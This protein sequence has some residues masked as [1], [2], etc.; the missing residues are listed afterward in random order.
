MSLFDNK[1]IK[2]KIE[3]ICFL[4]IFSIFTDNTFAQNG[5]IE[6]IPKEMQNEFVPVLH[7]KLFVHTDKT[8]YLPGELIWFKIYAIDGLLN[9]PSTFSKV[10]YV[11]II[12]ADNKAVLQTKISLESAIGKG[13]LLVP[14][15]ITS[16]NYTLRAYTQ[17]MR[18]FGADHFFEQS[19]SIVNTLK[20]S[21]IDAAKKVKTYHVQFFPEGGDLI[22]G[23]SSKLAFKITDQDNSAVA[24]KGSIINQKKDTVAHFHTLRFGMGSLL[25][26]PEKDETYTAIIEL[27]DTSITAAIPDALKKGFAMQVVDADS[28][29][30]KIAVTTNSSNDKSSI[31]F[32]AQSNHLVKNVQTNNLSNGIAV[33][34]VDKK[35]I[36]DGI[37][38]FTIFDAG[39]QPVCER[40]YFKRPT[41][42]L[43]IEL[44]SDQKK[45]SIRNKVNVTVSTTDQSAKFANADLSMS[46][47]QTNSFQTDVYQDIYNYLFLTSDLKGRIDSPE[48]YFSNNDVE[49]TDNLML[50]QG[51][52]KFKTDDTKK[53]KKPL[54]TFIPE[55]E[56]YLIKGRVFDK[57]TQLPAKNI[58]TFLSI[59]GESY[60]FTNSTSDSSGTVRY[61]LNKFY[62]RNS[63]IVQ[64]NNTIDSI[65][66]VDLENPFSDQSSNT[67]KYGFLLLPEWNKDL[68]QR[69]IAVQVENAYRIEEKRIYHSYKSI[70][71][72]AFY[73]I[74]DKKYF[75]DDYTRFRTMEEVMREFVSDVN[76]RLQSDHFSYKVWNE[77]FGNYFDDNP[78]VLIDGVPV[79]DINKI[80]AFDP[81]KVKKIE[82]VAKKYYLG[83]SINEGIIS[84][85]TYKGDLGGFELDPNSIVIEY[86]GLQ[87]QR[88]FYAPLY[89]NDEQKK[90]RLPDFRNV[91]TW[92]PDIKTDAAGKTKI[93]FYTSDIKGKFIAIIQGITKDGLAG[94]AI[95]HFD[96]TD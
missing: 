63:V 30:I 93:S 55:T 77:K 43:N 74:P 4:I 27:K 64:T 56:G 20:E 68:L 95:L 16:G 9:K 22:E 58:N 85:S 67:S 54:F 82:V 50:T 21:D 41:T 5:N 66:K 96:V 13:S 6:S 80:I 2:R 78:L 32:I 17:W 49:A 88:E 28:S 48:Y 86:E 45:Y 35:N 7:E 34:I 94:S 40:L 81:A 15:S 57:K 70:D 71:S 42:K 69:S 91:L 51:W 36:G 14:L 52:R 90:S 24:C 87:K 84:Y 19:I 29:H 23:L 83:S 73:G 75:L 11:E 47:F 18:N 33:F 8:F 46:V 62:G 31:Y 1:K 44:A 59:P 10:A 92:M 89:E 53:I 72:L 25:L 60:Q 79:F 26:T 38:T 65:Y 76:V 37:S 12:G 3:A 39:K 61:S